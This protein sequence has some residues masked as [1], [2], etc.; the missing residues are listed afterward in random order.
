[1]ITCLVPRVVENSLFVLAPFNSRRLN[2]LLVQN[3]RVS[4]VLTDLPLSGAEGPDSGWLQL[5]Q[6]RRN[7]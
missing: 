2:L 6:A 3:R 4:V 7:R 5:P 1:M